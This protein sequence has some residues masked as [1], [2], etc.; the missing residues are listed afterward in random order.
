[1]SK[2]ARIAI[3][4]WLG[5]QL[6]VPFLLKFDVP[7]FRHR[8]TRN[9]WGMFGTFDPHGELTVRRDG[10]PLPAFGRFWRNVRPDGW[11]AVT[12]HYLSVEEFE[13]RL[14]GYAR[15]L[16]TPAAPVTVEMRWIH[17]AGR[18]WTERWPD[19]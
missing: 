3:A 15:A 5:F 18:V 12:P 8:T 10:E 19:D 7:H 16:G 6:V 13:Q 14:A 11:A 1:M 4:I 2:G 9:S 17:P